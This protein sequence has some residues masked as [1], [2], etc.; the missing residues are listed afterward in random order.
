MKK[1]FLGL[2]LI[3]FVSAVAVRGLHA[4]TTTPP[5][6]VVV[7]IDEITDA[8]GFEALRQTADTTAVEVQTE[9]GRYF[10]RTENVTALD[11]SAPKFFAF[12]AFD[13]M[14]KAKAFNDNI[15]KITALRTRVTKS[16]SFIVEGTMR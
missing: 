16:R 12:I 8:N 5:V 1:Y 14:T 10:A 9:D 15:N 13:N 3:A 7:E 2:A 6:Y 4:R 11:G